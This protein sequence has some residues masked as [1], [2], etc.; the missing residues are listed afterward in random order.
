MRLNKSVIK[1]IYEHALKEYPD[2]CCG[3][4]TG[5][6][7]VQTVHPCRNIQ[8]MLH[9]EDPARYPR[10]ARTAY[11]I[12]RGEFDGIISSAKE[13]G[14]EII[15]FYHSHTEHEAY[16]SEEDFAAQTVLGELEFPNALHVVLSV[17][18]RKIHD[19]KPFMWDGNLQ[20]FIL[21]QNCC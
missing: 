21:V 8:N 20:K 5:N 3:I 10:D 18:N 1:K 9:A 16:F 6:S 17:M 11:F 12:E 4:I 19:I 15:A 2:E 13:K 14:E 7:N